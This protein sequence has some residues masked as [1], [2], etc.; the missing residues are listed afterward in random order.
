MS[1]AVKTNHHRL[2]IIYGFEL[3]PEELKEF[4]FLETEDEICEAQFVKYKGQLY[5]LND[6]LSTRPGPW[7]QGL[8]EEF[9]GWDGYCSDTFFSGM[10]VKYCDDYD[11]VII[12]QYYES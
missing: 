8:P 1:L 4:D 12:G 11:H 10:L 3:S 7:N 6:F 5:Y 9:K 2:P